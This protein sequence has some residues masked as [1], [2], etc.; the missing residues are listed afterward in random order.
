MPWLRYQRLR[1]LTSEII[2]STTRQRIDLEATITQ[3]DALNLTHEDMARLIAKGR[4]E[5]S[6]AF[7]A[8]I[9]SLVRLLADRQGRR[10]TLERM[11]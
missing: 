4:S 8:M 6:K 3:L 10:P 1:C 5:R 2:L 9:R 7:H 11:A